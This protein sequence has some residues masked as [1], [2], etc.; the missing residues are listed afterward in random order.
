MSG[1]CIVEAGVIH[2]GRLCTYTYLYMYMYM[3]MK[4]EHVNT[5][6]FHVLILERTRRSNLVSLSP[7][8]AGD[9]HLG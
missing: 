8:Q 7:V 2:S 6:K 1:L 5:S 4:V 3:Y 9:A